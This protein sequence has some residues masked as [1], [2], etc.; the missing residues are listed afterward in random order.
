M[1]WHRD[2]YLQDGTDQNKKFLY[3]TEGGDWRLTTSEKKRILLNNIY[4]VDIDAQAVEVTKLSLLLKVLEGENEQTLGNT[5][6][7]F[8]ERALPDLGNNIKCGNS[9]IGSD[10]Y[11]HQQLLL[12]DDEDRFRINVFD[13]SGSDGFQSIMKAGGFDAV[14][15]NP[16]WGGDIDNELEYFH[17]HYP[18]TTKD[19]TDSF[20]LFIEAGVRLAENTGLVSMIVPSTIRRQRRLRD[21]RELLLGNAILSVVDLGEDVFKGVVAPSC[22]YL[23]QKGKPPNGHNIEIRDLSRVQSVE[24]PSLL[25]SAATKNDAL[26]EQALLAQNPELELAQRVVRTHGPVSCLGDMAEFRCKDAGINYQRVR[27][28][29]RAKG[30]SDLADRLLYEGKQQR[31]RDR[32]FWKGSDIGTYWISK[33][34]QRFCRTD[35]KTRSNEVVHLNQDVYGTVPKI[36]LRQTADTIIAAMDHRGL[37]FGRSII[38]IVKESGNY[39]LEYLLGLLNSRFLRHVYEE[40]V[41]ESGRVFAQ[42]K[43][44]KLNQLPIRLID[45]SDSKDK[46]FHEKIAELVEQASALIEEQSRARTEHERVALK[47]QVEATLHQIDGVV[48]QLYGLDENDIKLIEGSDRSVALPE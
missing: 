32:M 29:M 35:V 38:A 26:V 6:R 20:K 8:H 24:R 33:S 13:W 23:V 14:I 28:G 44:S 36:L 19:H 22:I 41:H 42:V 3:K 47:R 10:F 45:F 25:L 46:K 2:W 4:G 17:A 5:L 30:N 40:L 27:V 7:L 39:K 34:T 31:S 11:L 21:V 9:L 12:I 37:W 15:G 48:Y 1:N 18:A 43:L 16:P